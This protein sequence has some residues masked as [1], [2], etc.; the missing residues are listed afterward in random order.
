MGVELMNWKNILKVQV[1]GNKQKVKMGLKPL[2]KNEDSDCLRRLS[3]FLDK[4]QN[5]FDKYPSGKNAQG[6]YKIDI[7]D[8]SED[9][10]CELLKEL[11]RSVDNM[12]TDHVWWD[13]YYS[14]GR[15][16]SGETTLHISIRNR[17]EYGLEV[18]SDEGNRIQF[19]IYYTGEWMDGSHPASFDGYWPESENY[20]LEDLEEELKKLFREA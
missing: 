18:T 1:L 6:L 5:L 8:M 4:L 20:H 16:V 3:K 9:S 7:L 14:T 12:M 11:N 17:D 10:A 19:I 15:A 13:E 2:P